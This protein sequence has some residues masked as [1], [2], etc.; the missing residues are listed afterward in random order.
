MDSADEDREE[1]IS[2]QHFRDWYCLSDMIWTRESTVFD[3]EVV[4]KKLVGKSGGKVG[5]R[6]DRKWTKEPYLLDAQCR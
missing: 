6:G 1:E 4:Q 3:G 2:W 5:G